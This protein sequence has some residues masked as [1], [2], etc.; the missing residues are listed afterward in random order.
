MRQSAGR[1]GSE[2]E[3]RVVVEVIVSVSSSFYLLS[4]VSGLSNCGAHKVWLCS[5]LSPPEFD[6][7][8][9]LG[10]VLYARINRSSSIFNNP[11]LPYTHTLYVTRSRLDSLL[12]VMIRL[13]NSTP[14]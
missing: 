6:A 10:T 11:A 4:L 7:V 13:N 8:F 9:H 5:S 12:S 2:G 3:G 14:C 1:A